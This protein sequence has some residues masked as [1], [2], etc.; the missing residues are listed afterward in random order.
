[1]LLI[2]QNRSHDLKVAKGLLV[3]DWDSRILSVCV[4][5]RFWFGF[6]SLIMIK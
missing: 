6:Y 1:M 4:M 3:S 5:H 2:G